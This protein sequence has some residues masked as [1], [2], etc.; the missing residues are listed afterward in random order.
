MD[1]PVIFLSAVSAEFR[2]LRQLLH[3]SFKTHFHVITQD[4]SLHKFPGGDVRQLLS[5]AIDGSHAVLHLAGAGFGSTAAAPFPE[6]PGFLCSWTQYEYY[7]AH[8]FDADPARRKQIFAIVCGPTLRS[9]TFTEKDDATLTAAQKDP[10]QEAHCQRIFS[11]KF[12][13][14]PLAGLPRT[15]NHAKPIDD[16]AAALRAAIDICAQLATSQPA[17]QAACTLVQT[18]LG[19]QLQPLL[20]AQARLEANQEESHRLSRRTLVF[21][22]SSIGLLSVITALGIWWLG[23]KDQAA[24][25]P[26]L[27]NGEVSIVVIMGEDVEYERKIRDS[28]LDH[29]RKGLAARGYKLVSQIFNPGFEPGSYAAPDD[30]D[31]KIKSPAGRKWSSTCEGYRV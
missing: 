4:D 20:E 3:D 30:V 7:Y 21:T 9:P 29:L 18:A 22:V 15:V 25:P 5:D 14:T 26:A 31:S 17:F 28:F 23:H 10:L 12:D 27:D 2:E 24:K 11:G 1:R 8:S 16:N 13:G 19:N 6:M